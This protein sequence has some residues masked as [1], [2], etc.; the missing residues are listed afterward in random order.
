MSVHK[1]IV[2]APGQVF[3][4]AREHFGGKAERGGAA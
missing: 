2:Q 3:E 1:P 4:L